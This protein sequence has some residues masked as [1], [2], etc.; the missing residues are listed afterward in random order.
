M[1]LN[2]IGNQLD[3]LYDLTWKV[4]FAEMAEAIDETQYALLCSM[5]KTAES[6]LTF[7]LSASTLIEQIAAELGEYG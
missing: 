7:H 1:N 2:E 6:L 5:I 4:Q 3:T